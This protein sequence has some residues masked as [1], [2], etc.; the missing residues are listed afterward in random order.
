MKRGT[1]IYSRNREEGFAT[2]GERRCFWEC[3]GRRIAVRW[4]D[5]RL[6]Y[7]CTRV[8]IKNRDGSWTIL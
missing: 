2:G 8:M 5:G 6:T 4:P 1:K 3:P 7:P